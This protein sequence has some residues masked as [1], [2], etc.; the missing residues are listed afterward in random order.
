MVD[1]V[2]V[3]N[4]RMSVEGGADFAKPLEAV[5]PEGDM[6]VVHRIFIGAALVKNQL[7]VV[8]GIGAQEGNLAAIPQDAP[9]RDPQ[10]EDLGKEL[11]FRVHVKDMEAGVAKGYAGLEI[12]LVEFTYI[13]R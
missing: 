12:H 2:H 5:H 11:H 10:A 9:V 7:M 1:G 8:P 3:G 13:D 6:V 4:A